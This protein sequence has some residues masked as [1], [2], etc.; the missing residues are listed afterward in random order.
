MVREGRGRNSW[1]GANVL[2]SR[3]AH[4]VAVSWYHPTTTPRGFVGDAYVV[5]KRRDMTM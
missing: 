4:V 2:V 3:I 1:R 5:G